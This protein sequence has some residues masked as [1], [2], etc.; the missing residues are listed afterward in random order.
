MLASQVTGDQL[1][2]ILGSMN[3]GDVDEWELAVASATEADAHAGL[4]QV[5]LPGVDLLLTMYDPGVRYSAIG[6]ID[7]PE[8][9]VL[10]LTIEAGFDPLVDCNDR[11]GEDADLLGLVDGTEA[12]PDAS[13]IDWVLAQ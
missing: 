10:R 9:E 12:M 5:S 13:W 6:S 7:H 2:A 1:E 4:D 3:R 11:G 8:C